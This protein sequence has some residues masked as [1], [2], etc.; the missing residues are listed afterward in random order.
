MPGGPAIDPTAAS[1]LDTKAR[2]L[3]SIGALEEAIQVQEQAVKLGKD[4]ADMGATLA[5]YRG[6]LALRAK[7]AGGAAP[8][9]APAPAAIP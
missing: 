8:K 2:I 9:A 6:L 7:R 3:Y 1:F 5:F 4:P